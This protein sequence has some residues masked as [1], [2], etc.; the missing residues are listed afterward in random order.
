MFEFLRNLKEA[1]AIV[2][3]RNALIEKTFHSDSDKISAL[4][5]QTHDRLWPKTPVSGEDAAHE[6][7]FITGFRV[8]YEKGELTQYNRNVSKP[9][10]T[11][12]V[13]DIH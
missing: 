10:I 12:R 3:E 8:G 4:A 2:K 13:S 1:L 7:G 9:R 11:R 5:W 6:A